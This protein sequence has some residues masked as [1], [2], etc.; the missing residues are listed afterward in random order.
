MRS[1]WYTGRMMFIE[2]EIQ[3]VHLYAIHGDAFSG[4]AFQLATDL[5]LDIEFGSVKMFDGA[6]N[7]LLEMQSIK[8][9]AQFIAFL[10]AGL[11]D[12]MVA[13]VEVI[14]Y[15]S[16]PNSI[17]LNG[18]F[19]NKVFDKMEVLRI[20]QVDMPQTKFRVLSAVNFTPFRC[21]TH[22]ILTKCGIEVIED[23]AFDVIGRNLK[24][25]ALFDNNIKLLDVR[26]FHVFILSK[27]DIRFNLDNNPLICTCRLVAFDVLTCILREIPDILCFP[28]IPHDFDAA[29]CGIYRV[30]KYT[31]FCV[32]LKGLPELRIIN[33]HLDY[34]DDS[35]LIETNYTS[36]FRV[37]MLN[38]DTPSKC[39]QRAA[40][41]NFTCLI[42]DKFV[43]QVNLNAIDGSHG[44]GSISV[45][46]ISITGYSEITPMHLMTVKRLTINIVELDDVWI[47]FMVVTVIFAAAVGFTFAICMHISQ[48]PDSPT[49]TTG[50]ELVDEY[51][52]YEYVDP[53][54]NID[55]QLDEGNYDEISE[56]LNDPNYIEFLD[57]T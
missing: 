39:T 31:Q 43:K 51:L 35:V 11:F 6:F 18:M 14:D 1:D 38:T 16:W 29:T 46:A 41:A 27:S 47:F 30:V 21:L 9:I 3:T 36:K 4:E 44:V 37:F 32:S 34:V 17:D 22:L 8:F 20:N 24:L 13:T 55:D 33:V 7:G 25:I 53:M 42:V 49:T 23:D 52:P 48:K 28:C 15:E 19:G 56:R 57:G 40:K 12:G 54:Q 50:E 2:M 45:I 26:M 5:I 10:P